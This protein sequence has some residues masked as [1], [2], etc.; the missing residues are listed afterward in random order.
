LYK[1]NSTIIVP[2][3]EMKWEFVRAVPDHFDFIQSDAIVEFAEQNA[4]KLR[5]HTLC[6]GGAFMPDWTK[7]AINKQTAMKYLTEHIAAVA[8]GYQGKIHSWDVVN[9]AIEVNDGRSD[10]LRNCNWLDWLGIDY[11][12]IAFHEARKADPAAILTYNDY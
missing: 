12:A 6:W 11:I 7:Q 10:G 1:Q 2:E 8:G 5:G 3:N 9:E 4:M